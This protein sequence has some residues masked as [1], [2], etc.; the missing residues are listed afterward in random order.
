MIVPEERMREIL[1][2]RLAEIHEM[3]HQES[4]TEA[5]LILVKD[6]LQTIIDTPV[7]RTSAEI[8]VVGSCLG[9]FKR[10]ESCL[11]DLKQARGKRG[12]PRDRDH[13][14]EP[15]DA[16]SAKC[17]FLKKE[18]EELCMQSVQSL[19]KEMSSAR[20]PRIVKK[21]LTPTSYQVESSRILNEK[22]N[23]LHRRLQE[24]YGD[25]ALG[26]PVL[27]ELGDALDEAHRYSE[28][29]G[30][31]EAGLC[32]LQRTGQPTFYA[33][34]RIQELKKRLATMGKTP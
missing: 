32:H 13:E 4:N 19:C 34:G 7:S 20:L 30:Q 27:C 1:A 22:I 10:L 26:G 3:I 2:T 5:L 23:E 14:Y 25:S 21:L 6:A 16:L 17:D 15:I 24:V 8:E 31:Y 12:V 29:L 11:V 28:A 9:N 33:E 18:S